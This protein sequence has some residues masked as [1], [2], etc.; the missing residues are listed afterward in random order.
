MADDCIFCRIARGE[1]PARL[2]WQDE[3]IVAFHDLNP[4]APTHVLLIPR[5]HIA[6]LLEAGDDDVAL[7]GRLQAAAVAVAKQLGLAESG[8]R[9]VTNCLESAGQSVFHLHVHLLGGRRF[10]W[11]PG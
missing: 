4:Q 9:L 2:A 3:E 1:I 6:T 10:A 7:L 11:P 8:F 5:R